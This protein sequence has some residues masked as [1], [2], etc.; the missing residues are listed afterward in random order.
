M[1][2]TLLFPGD[3]FSLNNPNDN[4]TAELDA[5]VACDNLDPLLYNYDECIDGSPLRLSKPASECAEL[6]IYRGWMMKPEQYER[7]Y[8][9]L[10]N[11]GFDPLTEPS[12]YERMHCFPNAAEPEGC[13]F[14]SYPG[15]H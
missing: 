10:V 14:E 1:R 2:A 5:V 9:D 8:D 3:Y 7:F 13:R 11:L 4:F 15:S 12:S 6:L